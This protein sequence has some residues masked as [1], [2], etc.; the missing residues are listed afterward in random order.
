MTEREQRITD[1]S[2]IIEQNEMLIARELLKDEPNLEYIGT[3]IE[4]N[5]NYARNIREVNSASE[6]MF[7]QHK[8][9]YMKVDPPQDR[10]KLVMKELIKGLTDPKMEC[11]AIGP[12]GAGRAYFNEQ[13]RKDFIKNMDSIYE[14]LPE[15]YYTKGVVY[16][17][18]KYPFPIEKTFCNKNF[19]QH[20]TSSVYMAGYFDVL[21]GYCFPDNVYGLSNDMKIFSTLKNLHYLT[22]MIDV[23]SIFDR[24]VFCVKIYT[25]KT[26]LNLNIQIN[27]NF[28]W[29]NAN[30]EVIFNNDDGN[31]KTYTQF[32]EWMF[33]TYSDHINKKEGDSTNA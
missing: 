10:G 3:L 18:D 9:I 19:E 4:F 29:K 7:E 26:E 5:V 30:V 28:T 11:Y 8:D 27:S 20:D 21:Q 12:K 22:Q 2:D 24:C 14:D 23:M 31:L 16:D 17:K 32:K 1:A 6:Q 25:S 33:L 15:E 13:I